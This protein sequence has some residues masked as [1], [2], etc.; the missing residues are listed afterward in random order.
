MALNQSGATMSTTPAA[1][2]T[3]TYLPLCVDDAGCARTGR[4]DGLTP[5]SP[6]HLVPDAELAHRDVQDF[7][8]AGGGAHMRR[9]YDDEV[10]RPRSLRA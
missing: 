4:D 9:V 5:V 8:L 1:R 3:F 6:P 10:T 2:S 7:A